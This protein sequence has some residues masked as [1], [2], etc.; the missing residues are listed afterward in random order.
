VR[1]LKWISWF[2]A[3]LV[4]LILLAMA[5]LVWV[6]DPNGFKPR[7]EAAVR[8]ATGREFTLVGNI[9]LGFFP[10]LS[11]RTGSGQFGNAPGFAAEPMASWRSAH[12]GVKV[13]PLLRGELE[14]DRIRLEGADV[15][16]T[17]RADG[18]ANWEGIGAKQP[19]DPKVKNRYVI[20]DGVD[21]RDSRLLFVDAAA[22][23]RV[24][25]TA[26]NLT[27]DGIAPDQPFTGTEIQGDLHL[28]GF[29][30]AGVP[31]RLAVPKA[32]LS[33]DYSSVDV[34]SFE[35][36]LGGMQ[37]GGG[38]SGD[39]G[40]TPRLAGKI[41]SNTFDVRAL[42]TAMGID[43]P[44]TNDPKALT[45][46]AVKG[47]WRLDAGGVA[48]DPLAVTL[49]D[50]RF[51]GNF[52]RGAGDEPVGDFTLRGDRLDI[53]RYIPPTDP[54]S[55]PFVLPTAT[56][57]AL[58]FRGVVELEQATYEDTLMKGVTLRLLL[59]EQGLRTQRPPAPQGKS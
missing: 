36:K 48:V 54:N 47:S 22:P 2:F 19:A 46:V 31:F 25:I 28:D 24:E 23:R 16:L 52:Q 58:K 20:I 29:A 9:E 32:S 44:K 37:A 18:H 12:L 55:P 49:D 41:E 15:R 4:V 3:G 30:P 10:W 11:L 53:A 51:T 38:V 57:K 40:A 14:V 43:A 56:L 33:E 45:R 13:L 27:T 26:L 17:R 50:T 8:E 35:V 42:L 5:V 7:I 39:L 21:L 34:P 6:V 59:D 1:L